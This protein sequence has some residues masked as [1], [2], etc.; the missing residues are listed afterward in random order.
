MQSIRR[1]PSVGSGSRVGPVG[2]V[3]GDLPLESVTRTQDMV[4]RLASL[5]YSILFPMFM[6]Q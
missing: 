6:C 5:R 2:G 3:L 1:C 4:W